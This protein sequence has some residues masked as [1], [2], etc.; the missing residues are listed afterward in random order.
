[1]EEVQILYGIRHLIESLIFFVIS[2]YG[3]FGSVSGNIMKILCLVIFFFCIKRL[4]DF[5]KMEPQIVLNSI[6]ISWDSHAFIPW[7][8]I[9]YIK[10]TNSPLYHSTKHLE[11]ETEE[12]VEAVSLYALNMKPKKIEEK[13]K[14]Y[15]RKYRI[16]QLGQI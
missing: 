1:M 11:F 16:H 4:V 15:W 9:K 7:N 2:I 12:G 14:E 13:A 10:M 8:K 5:F 3:M 6:G